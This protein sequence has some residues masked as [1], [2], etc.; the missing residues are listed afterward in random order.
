MVQ[1]VKNPCRNSGFC[2]N[3]PHGK[4]SSQSKVSILALVLLQK[5]LM[6][7]VIKRPFLFLIL[8]RYSVKK[9]A[10]GSLFRIVLY[11]KGK[12]LDLKKIIFLKCYLKLTS[13]KSFLY[14]FFCTPS[15]LIQLL[16]SEY[17]LVHRSIL[18]RQLD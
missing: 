4:Q 1:E 10:V 17:L 7:V 12:C 5:N 15:M 13:T 16:I 2:D 14:S 8:K 3:Y 6:L 11:L 9:E 18:F